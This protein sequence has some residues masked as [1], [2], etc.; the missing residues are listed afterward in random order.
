[1][2]D[3][4]HCAAKLPHILGQMESKYRRKTGRWN[5]GIRWSG[6]RSTMPT[7]LTWQVYEDEMAQHL[8]TVTEAWHARWKT[9]EPRELVWLV[10]LRQSLIPDPAYRES[11]S[12]DH[13]RHI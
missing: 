2:L 4:S 13:V 1:M 6:L 3:L 10:L 5:N 8:H 7:T 9:N 11:G 12:S